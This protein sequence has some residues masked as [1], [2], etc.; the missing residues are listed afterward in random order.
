MQ[1]RSLLNKRV[2]RAAGLTLTLVLLALALVWSGQGRDAR[3]RAQIP[4][5]SISIAFRPSEVWLPSRDAI[6]A[7]HQCTSANFTCVQQVM[8]Q[9]GASPDAVAFYQLTAWFLSDIQNTGTVQLATVFNPWRANENDQPAL[10]GGVPQV[11]FPEQ[12]AQLSNFEGTVE[13]ADGYADLKAAYPN[14]M[15]WAPGPAFEGTETSDDGGQ[16]F[17]FDYRLLDGCHACAVVGMARFAFDFAPDGTNEGAHFLGLAQ[18]PA[19]KQ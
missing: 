16:R 4:S 8:Q 5:T 18:P 15:F 14:V 9:D 12:Q 2:P 11:I 1:A 19:A 10:L 6:I 13:R 17:I 7:L 3:V